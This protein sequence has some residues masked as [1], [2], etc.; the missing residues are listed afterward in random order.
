MSEPK[1]CARAVLAVVLLGAAAGVA[2]SAE[3]DPMDRAHPPGGMVAAYA[4]RL[5]LEPATREAVLAIVERSGERDAALREELHAAKRRMHQ[6]MSKGQS[7]EPAAILAE[8][9]AIGALEVALHK[10]R[11][12]AILEIRARLEP[13]QRAELM[14]IREEKR[15]HR[16]HRRRRGRD[17][18]CDPDLQEYCADVEPGAPSLLCLHSHWGHLSEPCRAAFDV[19]QRSERPPNR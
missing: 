11:L 10:N 14:R 3:A 18:D 7:P 2:V 6:L 16:S 4:E 15:P 1:R 19:S 17:A 13:E 12:A 5:G 9:D 8:A